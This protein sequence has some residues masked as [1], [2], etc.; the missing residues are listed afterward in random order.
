[1]KLDMTIK[2]NVE[3]A[4]HDVEALLEDVIDDEAR[5]F[6]ESLRRRL[7]IAGVRDIQVS[8]AEGPSTT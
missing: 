2:Y 7:A 6:V 4:D 3:A 8:V 1:M 5:A